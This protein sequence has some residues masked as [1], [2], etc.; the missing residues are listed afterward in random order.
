MVEFTHPEIVSAFK[1]E[2]VYVFI[3]LDENN[4]YFCLYAILVNNQN[5]SLI[6]EFLNGYP[7]KYYFFDGRV[8]IFNKYDSFIIAGTIDGVVIMWDLRVSEKYYSKSNHLNENISNKFPVEIVLRTP[9]FYSG[10]EMSLNSSYYSHKGA[11]IKILINHEN[12][13][14]KEIVTL[15][16]MNQ[17]IIWKIIELN[18]VEIERNYMNFGSKS[19]IKLNSISQINLFDTFINFSSHF[20]NTRVLNIHN[21][22][23]DNKENLIYFCSNSKVFK[24]DKY[25]SITISP[26]N[27]YSL[28]ESLEDACPISIFITTLDILFIGFSDGSL[29]YSTPFF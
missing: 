14:I 1:S 9:N 12:T 7:S 2:L 22:E 21:F 28:N 23:I 18:N 27:V 4:S 15:D 26:P 5:C 25:G 20:K 6:I 17:A 24:S 10:Q 29:G 11:I 19:K 3:D 13:I 16:I 8:T